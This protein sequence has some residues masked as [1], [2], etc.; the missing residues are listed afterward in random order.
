MDGSTKMSRRLANLIALN[1]AG[2]SATYV[3]LPNIYASIDDSLQVFASG[4][5]DGICVVSA[6]VHGIR[7]D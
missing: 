5:G 2:P 6:W 4:V 1:N 3:P 7:A